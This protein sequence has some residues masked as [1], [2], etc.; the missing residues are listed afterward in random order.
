MSLITQRVKALVAGGRLKTLP[1]MRDQVSRFKQVHNSIAQ[2]TFTKT[3]DDISPVYGINRAQ[4][5]AMARVLK[6]RWI[7]FNWMLIKDPATVI[8]AYKEALG[9]PVSDEHFGGVRYQA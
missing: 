4:R 3:G 5:R 8:G 1:H 2:G 9:A 6:T 7:P